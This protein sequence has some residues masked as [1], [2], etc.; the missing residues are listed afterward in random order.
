MPLHAAGSVRARVNAATWRRFSSA[1]AP[2]DPDRRRLPKADAL[3]ARLI[4]NITFLY[5][6][7]AWCAILVRARLP[8]RTGPQL[9]GPKHWYVDRPAAHRSL[10]H[11]GD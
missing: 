2:S 3:R 9:S 4:S 8:V 11:L 10:Q 5:H 6:S 1:E 7:F